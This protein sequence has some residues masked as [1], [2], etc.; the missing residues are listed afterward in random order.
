MELS[1]YDRYYYWSQPRLL[2]TEDPEPTPY[3][4]QGDAK[5]HTYLLQQ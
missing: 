3:A 1:F 4:F 5:Q 2:L